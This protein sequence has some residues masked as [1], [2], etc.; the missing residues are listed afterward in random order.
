MQIRRMTRAVAL[1]TISMGW[2]TACVTDPSFER[3]EA[4]P[5]GPQVN[6]AASAFSGGVHTSHISDRY[7]APY[8]VVWDAAKR[9]IERVEQTGIRPTATFDHE[10]GVILLT[11]DHREDEAKTMDNPDTLRI[12]G[13][14]D[15][16][17]IEVI[18][19]SSTQTKVIVSRKVLGIPIDRLCLNSPSVCRARTNYE[20]EV[21]NGRIEDWI[22]TQ[23]EDDVAKRR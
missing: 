20:P 7:A 23:I 19:L 22:L 8:E 17:R 2:L 11:E 15:E 18:T 21:S 14:M 13:W 12:K 16:F 10:K 3:V 9:V 4:F 1:G 5:K 6:Q